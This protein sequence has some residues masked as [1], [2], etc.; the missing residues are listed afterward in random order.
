MGWACSTHRIDEKYKQNCSGEPELN[1]PLERPR[2]DDRI[3]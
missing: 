1:I 3:I 2:V